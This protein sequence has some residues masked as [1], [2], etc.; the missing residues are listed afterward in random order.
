MYTS[1]VFGLRPSTLP[2]S[3]DSSFLCYEYVQQRLLGILF[4]NFISC[5]TWAY[6]YAF[7]TSITI[8]QLFLLD[9]PGY[10]MVLTIMDCWVI[11]FDVSLYTGWLD[12]GKGWCTPP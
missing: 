5:C 1:C 6:I 8:D 2:P 12:R 10:F 4:L 9:L 3:Q 7:T 11:E